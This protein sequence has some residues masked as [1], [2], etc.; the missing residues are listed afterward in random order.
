MLVMQ[1]NDWQMTD[2]YALGEAMRGPMTSGLPLPDFVFVVATDYDDV[3]L[4][5]SIYRAHGEWIVPYA[6]ATQ[7]PEQSR[8]P[9]R[10]TGVRSR[11][12]WMLGEPPSLNGLIVAEGGVAHQELCWF[13]MVA[14]PRSRESVI[15]V[16]GYW[17]RMVG[18]VKHVA[19]GSVEHEL[20]DG[21]SKHPGELGAVI[22]I[23]PRRIGVSD[24]R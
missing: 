16:R 13:A 22:S 8:D 10:F 14:V 2:P 20:I 3:P 1:S 24:A 12:R 15:R 4:F 5:T 23:G 17:W 18:V 9:G 6:H 19:I 11:P 7:Q 21:G